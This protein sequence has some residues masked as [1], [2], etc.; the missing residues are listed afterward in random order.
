MLTFYCA[1]SNIH[2]GGLL[3]NNP[4]KKFKYG[5]VENLK[6]AFS[7]ITSLASFAMCLLG[8]VER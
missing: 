8:W 1:F 7:T 6:T 5:V 4:L 2:G 3:W